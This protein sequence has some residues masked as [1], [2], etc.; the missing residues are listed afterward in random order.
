MCIK[1]IKDSSQHKKFFSLLGNKIKKNQYINEKL[2]IN[3]K[4]TLE[5]NIKTEELNNDNIQT[6]QINLE[7]NNNI[8]Q[9]N[10]FDSN[11]NEN[12]KIKGGNYSIIKKTKESQNLNGEELKNAFEQYIHMKKKTKNII[13]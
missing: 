12:N 5:D 4:T 9:E 2:G 7:E 6:I 11:N 8:K 1:C 10:N 13:Y 3:K